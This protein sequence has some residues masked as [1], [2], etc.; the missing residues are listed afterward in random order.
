[1]LASASPR[2]SELLHG[3]GLSFTVEPA[4]VDETVRTGE[5]AES[6]V[7]RLS[8]AKADVVARRNPD[9]LV[10]AADTTVVIDDHIINKPADAQENETF[11]AALSGHEHLVFTGHTL[12][13]GGRSETVVV[14]TS[15]YFRSLSP[16]E[17]ARYV[18]T[19]EGS[20]KAGGYAIQGRGAA[21]VERIEGCYSS[22]VGLS[23]PAVVTAS[24]R[25]GV[26]LV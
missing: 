13:C 8:A 14:R 12:V 20:D 16:D 22:V 10:I 23:L 5:R 25:L 26:E 24:A 19:G 4:D 17:I 1:M 9:A 21:L 18:A 7:A 6:L 3:L 2:R 11:L 15:V